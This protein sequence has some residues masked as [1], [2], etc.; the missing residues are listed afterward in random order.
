MFTYTLDLHFPRFCFAIFFITSI[1]DILEDL[2]QLGHDKPSS[3][4]AGVDENVRLCILHL[5]SIEC[6]IPL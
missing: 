5:T 2:L 1:E 4:F 6:V 3:I